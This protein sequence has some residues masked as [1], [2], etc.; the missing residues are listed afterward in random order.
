MAFLAY[1]IANEIKTRLP[2]LDLVQQGYVPVENLHIRGDKATGCCPLHDDRN[3]SFGFSLSENLWYCFGC[4][5]GGDVI[6]LYS[7]YHGISDKE[8]IQRLAAHL[9]LTRPLPPAEREKAKQEARK[10]EREKLLE[11]K[12]EAK[13]GE[14]AHILADEI[15]TMERY[16][17]VIRDAGRDPLQNGLC[18]EWLRKRD[19]LEHWL[20]QL[21]AGDEEAKVQTLLEVA[22]WLDL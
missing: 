7:R 4:V 2:I 20:D 6:R 10:R 15:R 11:A 5:G 8:A 9:G 13:I 22:G 19:L 21:I 12:L 14:A 1:S 17:L 18:C 16:L 3:P